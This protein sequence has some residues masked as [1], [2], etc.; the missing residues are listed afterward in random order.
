MVPPPLGGPFVPSPGDMGSQGT[1]FGILPP[2]AYG[3]FLPGEVYTGTYTITV[4]TVYIYTEP[5]KIKILRPEILK[6]YRNPKMKWVS[7][8]RALGE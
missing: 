3:S 1:G 8:E 5:V 7:N 6:A 4:S 2:P